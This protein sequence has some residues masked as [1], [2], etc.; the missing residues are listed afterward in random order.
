MSNFPTNYTITDVVYNNVLSGQAVSY[1]HTNAVLTISP[2]PGYEIK[3]ENFSIQYNIP[4]VDSVVFT[5]AGENII[6]TVTFNPNWLMPS[7]DINIPL[8]LNGM[9]T[10]IFFLIEG[11]VNSNIGPNILLEEYNANP[12]SQSG[13]FGEVINGIYS[14]RLYTEPGYCFP[15][16]P[17]VLQTSG[18]NDIFNIVVYPGDYDEFNNLIEFYIDINCTV[19]NYYSID[20]IFNY[21]IISTEVYAPNT[22]ITGYLLDTSNLS[23]FGEVRTIT[24]FGA[25]NA[26]WALSTDSNILQIGP[27]DPITNIIPY[28]TYASG[29]IDPSGLTT[30][31]INIPANDNDKTY[32]IGLYGDLVDGFSQPNPIILK[33]YVNITITYAINPTSYFIGNGNRYNSGQPFST[34]LIGMDGYLNTFS[35]NIVTIGNYGMILVT[36]PI[37]PG[38]N[39]LDALTNGGTVLGINELTATQSTSN[40]I[41]LNAIGA[42]TVYGTDNILSTLDPSKFIAFIDTN[43]I[44]AITGTSAISGGNVNYTGIGAT[45]GGKGICYSTTSPPTFDDNIVPSTSSFGS[46]TSNIIELD[47]YTTYYVRAYAYTTLGD[48]YYG[49]EKAFITCADGDSCCTVNPSWVKTNA[50]HTTYRDGTIIPQ[51]TDPTEWANA[52]TGAWCWYDNDSA[53]EGTYGKLY[54]WF[55]VAGIYDAASLANPSLRKT[56]APNGYYVPSQDD[57]IALANCLGGSAIAG[58]KM[59]TTGTDLWAAP[60]SGATNSSQFSGLPGGARSNDGSFTNIN[61]YGLW[62]S[63]TPDGIGYAKSIFL[64]YDSEDLII[65]NTDIPT[66]LSVRLIEQL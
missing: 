23:I 5:Q 31:F 33:Q 14:A 3:A 53:N 7:H 6:C 1:Y 29:I 39:N 37:A 19:P 11:I 58:A 51:V 52:Q 54:N 49:P 44:T 32:T 28:G 47:P 26:E 59:K 10:L 48:V 66:G 18:N 20:N 43:P 40:L 36:Q 21:S 35:W 27:P 62:W 16:L 61:N 56:F 38:F 12:F 9:G 41:T 2:L 8:C 13:N 65:Y 22:K 25:E 60:N 15:A 42:V 63:S 55:A 34:P 45:I 24:I 17:T 50:T 57:F 64:S 46:F 4:N 30:L